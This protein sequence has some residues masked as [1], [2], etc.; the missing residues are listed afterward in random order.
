MKPNQGGRHFKPFDPALDFGVLSQLTGFSLRRAQL[1]VYGRFAKAVGDKTVTPL[2]F[3]MLELIGAN[4]GLQQAQLA[5]ALGLSRPT[6]TLTIDYWEERGFVERRSDPRD[7]RSNGIHITPRGRQA[8]SALQRLVLAH[9]RSITSRL[10]NG[11]A[12]ELHRL[13]ARVYHR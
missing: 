8:L 13:L 1:F 9:D 4:P 10:T 2:R 6:A 11:E 3:S 7:R 12:E 5:E